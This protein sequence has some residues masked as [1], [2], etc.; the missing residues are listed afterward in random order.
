MINFALCFPKGKAHG[1][2]TFPK[3]RARL[4]YHLILGPLFCECPYPRA[5]PFTKFDSSWIFGYSGLSNKF[6]FVYLIRKFWHI[7]SIIFWIFDI[8]KNDIF[9][10]WCFRLELFCV[11]G[12]LVIVT[13]T[14]PYSFRIIIHCKLNFIWKS[15]F[16]FC[17]VVFCYLFCTLSIFFSIYMLLFVLHPFN[18]FSFVCLYFTINYSNELNLCWHFA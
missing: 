6:S 11:E 9:Q 7:Y 18:F 16:F 2:W 12:I 3:C 10:W 15:F 8:S 13:M 1:W 5:L 14:I 17:L 4:G